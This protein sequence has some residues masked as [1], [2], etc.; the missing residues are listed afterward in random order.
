[1]WRWLGLGDQPSKIEVENY[2][3]NIANEFKLGERVPVDP[4]PQVDVSYQGGPGH[5]KVETVFIASQPAWRRLG[6]GDVAS[7]AEVKWHFIDKIGNVAQLEAIY[8]EIVH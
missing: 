8:V 3:W 7:K 6:F 4:D 2:F 1:M 5:Y